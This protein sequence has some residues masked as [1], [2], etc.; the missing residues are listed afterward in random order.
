M[1]LLPITVGASEKGWHE[2]E[3]FVRCPQEYKFRRVLQLRQKAPFMADALS[4]GICVHAARAQWLHDKY[5]GDDWRRAIAVAVKAHEDAGQPLAPAASA[6]A[7]DCMQAYVNHWSLRPKPIPLAVEYTI[8]PRALTPDAPTWTWRSA[9]L[10][11]IERY[12]GKVWIGECKTTSAHAGQVERR[13]RLHG[14]L[15]LQCALWGDEENQRFGPL[16]GIL[17]DVIVKP[18]G[19]RP[20]KACA[21][22]PVPL[23]ELTPAIEWFKR[24]FPQWI[25]QASLIDWNTRPQRRPTACENCDFNHICRKGRAGTAGFIFPDGSKV[26]DW[27]PTEERT[28]PP[29]K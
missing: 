17:L 11:S 12:R 14:Q 24:D 2:I 28:L 20:A 8:A 4:T 5:K 10:D 1:S 16:A 15:L 13:Y 6:V 23:S 27:T 18:S 19:K 9:R 25:M 3:P 22:I 26:S 7:L 21:R 29:W